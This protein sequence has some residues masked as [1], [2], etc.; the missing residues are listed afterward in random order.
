MRKREDDTEEIADMTTPEEQGCRLLLFKNCTLPQLDST[1]GLEQ[2]RSCSSL[3]EWLKG[4]SDISEFE[5]QVL[6]TL[7]EKL[8]VGVDDW[9]ETELAYNFVGPVMAFV[10]YTSRKCNF[11][12]E[13]PFSG[14]V[15]EI[16]MR[17]RPDG[18]IAS[19]VRVPKR[20]YFCFQEYKKEKNPE[21]DPAAQTLA[22]MLVAQ[23][24]SEHRHPV[25]G[26]YVKGRD[27]FFMTL[28]GKQ[29]AISE[30]YIAT[31]DDIFDIFRILRVL[32]QIILAFVDADS[33]IRTQDVS[34]LQSP[35]VELHGIEANRVSTTA[36]HYH[37]H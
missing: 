7:R 19:G 11:F 27:W 21:G 24:L 1:F 2:I 31:R 28:Q 37:D 36:P 22:A 16:E 20:P 30:P 17:G 9:N 5:R 15:G 14:I 26:C 35:H 13:R 32:K 10:N 25:C 8:I 12:A 23:E 18:M 33:A 34:D 6:L 3:D 4:Q 29:Y